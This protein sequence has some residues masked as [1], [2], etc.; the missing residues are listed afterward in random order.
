MSVETPRAL[1]GLFGISE[2]KEKKKPQGFAGAVDDETLAGNFLK[3][4]HLIGNASPMT[5]FSLRCT[6][7]FL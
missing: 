7:W 5:L 3:F 6:F 1:P 2:A 4:A